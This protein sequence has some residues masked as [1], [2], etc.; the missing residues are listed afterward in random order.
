MAG[1]GHRIKALMSHT[2]FVLHRVC[3]LSGSNFQRKLIVPCTFNIRILYNAD[4]LIINLKTK[5]LVGR[6]SLR[7]TTTNKLTKFVCHH[8]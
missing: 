3:S 1:V 4:S 7:P 8:L 2:F 5:V 6:M